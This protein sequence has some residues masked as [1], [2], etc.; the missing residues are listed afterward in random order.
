MDNRMEFRPKPSNHITHS[1]QHW[2][3]RA[4]VTSCN[5]IQSDARIFF[6]YTFPYASG[7]FGYR[8]GYHHFIDG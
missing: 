3:I 8:A 1:T 6:S 7:N 4:Y 2:V 5:M